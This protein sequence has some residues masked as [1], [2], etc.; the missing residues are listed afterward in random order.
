MFASTIP[1]I[2]RQSTADLDLPRRLI[3]SREENDRVGGKYPM[4]NEEMRPLALV[5]IQ[6]Q[7][8]ELAY[9]AID[10]HLQSPYT[11]NYQLNVQRQLSDT[12]MWEIGYVGIRGIK[13]PM[14]RRYNLPDRL[15]GERPN[16]VFIPSGTYVSADESVMNH[17]LQT[18]YRKRM[19]NNLS[20]DLH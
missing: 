13:F 4:S 11:I 8:S 16:P 17:S 18:S 10:N 7:G 1:G 2:L 5:E 14:H 15:T 12:M 3:F 19:S 6:A 9:T 20:F